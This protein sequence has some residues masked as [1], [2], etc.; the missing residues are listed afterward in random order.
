MPFDAVPVDGPQAAPA[1]GYSYFIGLA[2]QRLSYQE[3]ASLLP[4]RSKAVVN[5][6]LLVSGAL[7]ALAPDI[8]F[9]LDNE[10][11]FAPSSGQ[12]RWTAPVATLFPNDP[13]AAPIATTVPLVQTNGVRIS[14]SSTRL[15]GLF[16]LQGPWFVHAGPSFHSQSFRR[17]A[18]QAGVDQ[19]VKVADTDTVEETSAEVLWHLGAGYESERVRGVPVHLGWRVDWA[20]PAWRKVE[21]TGHP[22][23]VF[24][25]TRGGYDLGLEGRASWALIDHVHLG[26][27]ARLQTSRRPVDRQGNVELPRTRQDNQSLGVEFLW[28]L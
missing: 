15:L 16:R 5:N 11:S 10:S 14:D 12:E 2:R 23:A 27:W 28:K 8:L 19:A 18:F 21:N 4:V 26:L 17:F 6:P 9:S 25:Q 22:G 1:A 7:Y 24:G 13:P 3:Y 20:L